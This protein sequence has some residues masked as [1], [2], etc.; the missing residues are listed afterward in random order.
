MLKL[1]LYVDQQVAA[2]FT[3]ELMVVWKKLLKF[4]KKDRRRVLEKKCLR[5][6]K[7]IKLAV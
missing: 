3:T 5:L 1:G 7:A 2:V 6:I 4:Y